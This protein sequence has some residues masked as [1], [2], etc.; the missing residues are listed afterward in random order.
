MTDDAR[1]LAGRYRVG[2]MIGRGGMSNVYSGW[3][4]KLGR[5]VAIK[6]LRSSL[7]SDPTFRRRFR[8]EAQAASRMAHPTIVRVFDA[9]EE[10]VI[11]PGGMEAVV[12]FIVM[13]FVDGVLLKDIIAKGPV[14]PAEAIRVTDGILTALEYSHRA[15]VVHRD[16]KPGNVMLTTTGQVKVMDFGIARA[17]SDSSATVAQT[18][19]V[20]GTAG[21]FSP[22]QARGETVDARSDLYSTGVVLFELLTGRVL[23]QGDTPV[24]VAYQ[25]VSEAP[26]V[27]SSFNPK[28]SPAL[29][30]V[31]AHALTK[32]KFARFQTAAEFREDLAIAATGRMPHR[33]IPTD[34]LESNLFGAGPDLGQGADV[35]LT[36]MAGDDRYQVRTQSRP[37]VVWIWAGIA[38]VAVILFAIVFWVF[39]LRTTEIVP[40]TS[41]EVPSMAGQT[42]S[43]ADSTLQQLNLVTQRFDAFSDT[44]EP[45]LVIRTNPAAG[46]MVSPG[47]VIEVYVSKGKQPATIPSVSGMSVEEATPQIE[48]A[49]LVVGKTIKENSAG[50]PGGAIIRTS[51]SP[52]SQVF[53]G[54][55]IDFVV[56]SGMVT[57]PDVANLPLDTATA[58]LSELSL[59]VKAEQDSSCERQSGNPI[60]RQSLAPGDVPQG[61]DITITY[62]TGS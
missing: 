58:Q 25:H 6:L 26:P 23:F 28:V 38:S 30:Q 59:K 10:N 44:T 49:G 61:A 56:S 15:G 42:Y 2:E 46:T 12:P 8:A 13:E 18:S 48:A 32:D 43:A 37:P 55:T 50:V 9:G 53:V 4:E 39:T 5:K 7:A 17:I 14:E 31:V 24:A 60:V 62:C 1:L 19:A 3:D 54:E 36:R 47:T 34:D 41:R 27:P 35:A 11:E 33:R 22:E 52:G 21:Y 40:D 57:I 16:I 20:L 29:D 51:P 45:G